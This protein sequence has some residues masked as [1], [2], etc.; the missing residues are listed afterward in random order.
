MLFR[1]RLFTIG[2]PSDMNLMLVQQGNLLHIDN[3]SWNGERS[4]FAFSTF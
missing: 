4:A 1:G 3:S 2:V